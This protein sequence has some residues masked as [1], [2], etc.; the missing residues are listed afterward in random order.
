MEKGISLEKLVTAYLDCR[1]R[2]RNTETALEFEFALEENLVKLYDDLI[3]GNYEISESICFIVLY[4]KPREVWAACFR[5]RVVHHLIYNEISKRF[6]NRFIKDTY[7]CIP[8]RGTTNAVKTLKRYV[9]AVTNDYT[10]TAYYLKAD[11]KNFFVSI[12]KNILYAEIK[13]LVP[14]DWLLK[15]IKQ[16]I[17]HDCKTKVEIKSS[18]WKFDLLPTYKSLW[19]TPD[20]KGLPIGNL[21]SQFFSNVYL[22]VLDQYVK[23]HWKCKYYCRYV[24]DFIILDKDP[25]KLNEIHKDLTRFLKERLALD[26]HQNKKSVNKIERG[27]DFVGFV[28]KPYRTILRQKTLKRIFKMIREQKKNPLWYTPEELQ[29]FAASIN[30]YL[31][32]LRNTNGYRLRQIICLQCINLFISCDEKFTKLKINVK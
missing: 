11:L 25:Q 16:V 17:F 13:K 14:E 23:H 31:G 6:Y 26:L 29:K 10:E 8:E 3:S 12:D 7:S 24:D 5:D 19:Y 27:I 21:T 1:R 30:S 9:R 28:A 20:E 15:L 18:K 2:K 4:P 22:N 32:I